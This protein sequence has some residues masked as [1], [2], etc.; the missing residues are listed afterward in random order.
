[1]PQDPR[2]I[3]LWDRRAG[4]RRPLAGRLV[5]QRPVEGCGSRVVVSEQSQ[6]CSKCG[7]TEL[8]WVTLRHQVPVDVLQCQRCS[9]AEVEEDWVVPLM[10]L[11]AGRC[12]N[13]GGNRQADVCQNCGLS[14]PDDDQVHDELR[15]LIAPTHNL[16]NAARAASRFGRRLI[17]LKLATAAAAKNVDDQG[18]VARALR[19]WLLSAI[20][21]STAALEDAKAWVEQ[22]PNPS[23]LAWASLGQQQ[24]HA[25]FPGSAADAYLK[26]L[27][28]DPKQ[29]RLRAARSAIL[30]QMNREGQAAE[31]ACQVFEARADDHSIAIALQVAEKLCY[32]M[33]SAFRDD[34]ISRLLARAG[35]YVDRSAHMLAHRARLAALN[36]D[37]S[38]ARKDL[39]KARR[40]NPDLEIYERIELQVKPQRNSWWRW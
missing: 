40:I 3:G 18:D 25:G 6:I 5:D 36:G 31:E 14:R 13:C 22:S 16:L 10:P 1:M 39:K 27:Q 4:I 35:A 19:V 24:Q 2:W 11:V 17:A 29:H 9:N 34:E 28:K 12:M 21:E 7:S 20:G 33:E 15:Q 32:E 8:R 26:A 37:E 23:H 38:G 30:M